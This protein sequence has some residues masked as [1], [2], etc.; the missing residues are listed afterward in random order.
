MDDFPERDPFQLDFRN[1]FF[2]RFINFIFVESIYTTFESE[3]VICPE[4]F[5]KNIDF[6]T[7]LILAVQPKK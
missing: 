3:E 1:I 2:F 5:F 6:T 4:L 7:I